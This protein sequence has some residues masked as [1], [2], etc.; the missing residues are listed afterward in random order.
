MSRFKKTSH[1]LWHLKYHL[2]WTTKYRFRILKGPVKA[3]VDRCLRQFCDR[4]KI[5]VIELNVQE[6]HVHLLA[7]IPPKLV[8]SDVMGHLKGRTAIRVFKTFPYLKKKP[9]WCNHFWT[10]GYC[11]DT[12]GVNEEQIRKY[13]KYQEKNER[14]Q[15]QTL[16]ILETDWW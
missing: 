12:I 16:R 11:A 5:E 10:R 6:D 4:L 13:V 7:S 8:I 15:E 14:L 1:A 3:E 2:I 9:Y